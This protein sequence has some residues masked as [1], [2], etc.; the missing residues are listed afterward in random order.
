MQTE[1]VQPRNPVET[2]IPAL[3]TIDTTETDQADI[4]GGHNMHND[5]TGLVVAACIHIASDGS[6]HPDTYYGAGVAV[7]VN[8]QTVDDDNNF[9]LAGAPSQY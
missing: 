8:E 6:H 2:W 7:M 1:P 3:P 9:I 4:M 5:K